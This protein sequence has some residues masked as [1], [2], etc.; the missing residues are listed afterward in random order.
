MA[1]LA[2][3]ALA[4]LAAS[5]SAQA[6]VSCSASAPSVYDLNVTSIDGSKFSLATYTGRVALILNVASF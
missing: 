1:L 4:L 6:P 3:S 5:A 2:V